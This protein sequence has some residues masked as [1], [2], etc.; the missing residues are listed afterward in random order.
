MPFGGFMQLRVAHKV[1][2]VGVACFCGLAISL[3]YI[4]AVWMCSCVWVC[5][6]ACVLL[7]IIIIIHAA[8]RRVATPPDAE[9]TR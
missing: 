2:S 3:R 1:G 9:A 4:C 5:G 6:R 7:I 8:L